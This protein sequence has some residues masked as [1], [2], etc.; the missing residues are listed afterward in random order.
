MAKAVSD[1]AHFIASAAPRLATV[2]FHKQQNAAMPVRTA[3]CAELKAGIAA[4]PDVVR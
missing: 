2:E 3:V 1:R 4:E